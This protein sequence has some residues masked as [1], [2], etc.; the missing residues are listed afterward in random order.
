MKRTVV[1]KIGIGV[2]AALGVMGA[3]AV[4]AYASESA[5]TPASNAPQSPSP[6]NPTGP[7]YAP[8]GCPSG[9]FCAYHD[10]NG[11]ALCFTTTTTENYPPACDNATWS[12]YNNSSKS[13][14]LYY[15]QNESGAYYILGP[16]DYLLY[17]QYNNFNNCANGTTTCAGYGQV[18]AA[19]VA[20]VALK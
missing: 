9:S 13:A 18:M 11:G 16:G 7:L 4:P 15:Q 17:M 8:S 14:Y 19:N 5:V 3:T 10:T 6:D 12:V 1:Q 20:S 2:T